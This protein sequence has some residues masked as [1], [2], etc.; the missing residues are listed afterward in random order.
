MESA[1]GG[2]DDL[3]GALY[4][5]TT[6]V[7]L[8]LA[9]VLGCSRRHAGLGPDSTGQL[10]SA[11]ARPCEDGSL[12]YRDRCTLLVV[13]DEAVPDP[14]QV[15]ERRGCAA[16]LVYDGLFGLDLALTGSYDAIVLDRMLPGM[17]RLDVC[18][19]LRRA[20]GRRS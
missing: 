14:G 5:V 1:L 12:E 11:T 13:D 18:H 4:A 17:D 15:L 9:G 2:D 3:A 10:M 19:Q 8:F 7:V 16:D 6:G 20:D